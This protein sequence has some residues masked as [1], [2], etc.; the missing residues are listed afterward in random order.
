MAIAFVV[1]IG[2]NLDRINSEHDF[3]SYNP[4]TNP[5]YKILTDKI[6]YD[7]IQLADNIKI[8][9]T[10]HVGCWD[11]D[12]PCSHRETIKAIKKFGY[13]IYYE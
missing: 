12:Q 4:L 2:R 11:L 13:I 9:I 1:F 10:K 6:E 5:Y 7:E 3:Y 8:N